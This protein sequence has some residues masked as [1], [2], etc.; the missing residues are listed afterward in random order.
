[1]NQ[2][3]VKA[4]NK[5]GLVFWRLLRPHTLTASFVPVIIGSALAWPSANFKLSLAAIMLLASLLLQSATNIFNEYYDYQ[6]GLDHKASVGIGGAIV[7]DGMPPE[8]VFQIAVGF[9]VVALLLGAYIMQQS[10]WQLLPWGLVCVAVGYLYSGGPYPISATPFG[11]IAAGACMGMGIISISYFI[12]TV[13]VDS[14]V[15]LVSM[16]PSVMIG[17]ILM[18]NNIR[19]LDEDQ[20]HGRKTLAVLFG[21]KKA[22]LMLEA[23]FLFAYLWTLTNVMIG[24]TSPWTL[25][26]LFSLPKTLQ[27]VEGFRHGNRPHELMP[28]MVATAQANTVFG[29]L[30]ALGLVLAHL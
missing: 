23:M 25:L 17:A 9:A 15:Y 2:L 8:R 10:S 18:A 12:Q 5:I 26:V 21:R 6:R 13:A 27:A 1:M 24:Q 28:A 4:G 16:A 20:A 14:L 3:S 11:E 29:L 7:R 30:L 22:I 19:D